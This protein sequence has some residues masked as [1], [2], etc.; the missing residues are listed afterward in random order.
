MDDPESCKVV[1]LG[2]SGVGK[3]SIINQFTEETFSEEQQST[4]GATF[5]S[6]EVT[7]LGGKKILKFEKNKKKVENFILENLKTPIEVLLNYESKE[8]DLVHQKELLLYEIDRICGSRSII[9]KMIKNIGGNVPTEE[10]KKYSIDEIEPNIYFEEFEKYMNEVKIMENLLIEKVYIQT[11]KNLVHA[12]Y[13]LKILFLKIF[14]KKTLL[15]IL[16]NFLKILLLNFKILH[17]LHI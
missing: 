3:T 6:K 13:V 10:P 12:Q 8:F 17:F 14:I 4:S 11:V 7:C 2:E 9:R 15:N 1:L 16:L 5:S